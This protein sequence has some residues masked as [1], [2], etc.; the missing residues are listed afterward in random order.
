MTWTASEL[1]R[2]LV[3]RGDLPARGRCWRTR[4]R[5]CRPPTRGPA[6]TSCS[7]RRPSRSRR[8]NTTWPWTAPC[9]GRPRARPQRAPGWPR[10]TGTRWWIRT[11][12]PTAARPGRPAPGGRPRGRRGRRVSRASSDAVHVTRARSPSSRHSRNASRRSR[13]A[14]SRPPAQ[15]VRSMPRSPMRARELPARAELAE[16]ADRGVRV[17]LASSSRIMRRSEPATVSRAT[18]VVNGWPLSG[19]P[20]SASSRERERLLARRRPARSPTRARPAL[21]PRPTGRAGGRR[22]R[23]AERLLEHRARPVE[24]VAP[25]RGPS[26]PSAGC[27]RGPRARRARARRRA[28][29]ANSSGRAPGSPRIVSVMSARYREACARTRMLLAATSSARVSADSAASNSPSQYRDSPRSDEDQR[30]ALPPAGSG[31]AS[32]SARS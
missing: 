14:A 28:P 21:G 27:A 17:L 30:L 12:P 19:R 16:R 18:A 32:A 23:V 24:V 26:R 4:P 7:R 11:G 8:A 9:P 22:A 6:P 13:S 31:P 15:P 1:A 5:G 2:L 25:V 3:V 20:R 29:R 10:R